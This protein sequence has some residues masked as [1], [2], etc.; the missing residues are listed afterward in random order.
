MMKSRTLSVFFGIFTM[1]AMA[2]LVP[3]FGQTIDSAGNIIDIQTEY[4]A[5][6]SDGTSV[7]ITTTSFTTGQPLVLGI[8]FNDT[9]GNFVKHQNYAITVMQDNNTI[10]SNPHGHTHTGM[11]IQVTQPLS[12]T[13][14]INIQM[15]L[16]GVGLPTN[17]PSTWTGVKGEVLSFSQTTSTNATVPEFG[18]VASIVLA[19]AVLSVVVFAAKTRVI[20]RF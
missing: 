9:N 1:I 6:A 7:V 17:D 13:D 18:P 4:T 15:T 2:G 5:K 14:Q 8:K 12:S 16:L 10:L 3:A 20:P 11:D 19:I